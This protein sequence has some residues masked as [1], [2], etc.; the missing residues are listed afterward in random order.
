MT[1]SPINARNLRFP[2]TF[3]QAGK[4]SMSQN[5]VSRPILYNPMFPSRR[6]LGE[7]SWNQSTRR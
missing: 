4:R 5:Y 1:I 2:R 6:F 3:S 7:S